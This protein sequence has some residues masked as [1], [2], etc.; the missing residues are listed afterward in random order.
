MNFI[1]QLN[2]EEQPNSWR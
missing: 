2:T 1:L